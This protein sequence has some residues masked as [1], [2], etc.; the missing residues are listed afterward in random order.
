MIDRQ[1]VGI[2]RPS[3]STKRLPVCPSY[4]L[5]PIIADRMAHDT[6]VWTTWISAAF[7]ISLAT[8]G[9]LGPRVGRTIDLLGGRGILAVSNFILATGLV[10]LAVSQGPVSLGVAW[11]VLEMGMGLGLYDTACATLGRIYGDTARGAITGIALT[12]GF[13]STIGWPLTARVLKRSSGVIPA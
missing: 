2:V 12:A 8:S 4:Y 3:D 11:L 10:L 5:P 7:S 9:M 6:G 1:R 13:S